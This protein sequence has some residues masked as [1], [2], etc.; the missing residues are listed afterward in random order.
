MATRRINYYLAY[1]EGVITDILIIVLLVLGFKSRLLYNR[2]KDRE[3]D[4]HEVSNYSNR[5]FR[6]RQEVYD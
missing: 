6:D 4:G 5:F 3:G 2:E 1:T